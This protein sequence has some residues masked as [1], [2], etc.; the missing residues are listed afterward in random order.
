MYLNAFW[1]CEQEVRAVEGSGGCIHTWLTRVNPGV[2]MI[3][4]MGTRRQIVPHKSSPHTQQISRAV[5]LIWK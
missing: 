1:N 3:V 4:T 5:K 2:N